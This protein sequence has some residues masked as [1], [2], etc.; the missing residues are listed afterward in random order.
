MYK[1]TKFLTYLDNYSNKLDVSSEHYNKLIGNINQY[2][3]NNN[4]IG[5]HAE[6][7]YNYIDT[8]DSDTVVNNMEHD[9]MEHDN[10][11]HDNIPIKTKNVNITTNVTCI[12]DL[13]QIIDENEYD[14]T[15]EYNI[16]LKSLHDI[17][18]ELDVLNNMIGMESIK[19]SVLNQMLYF[20]QNLDGGIDGGG[21]FKHTVLYGKPGTGKTEIAKLIGQIYSK[22]GILKNNVFKKVTRGDLIAGYLGQTAI[23]TTKVV[24]E[25]IGGV[26]FIDEAYSLAPPDG[27]DIFSKECLDTLCELL[28]DHK[29]DLMVII[30]GY[31]DDL[32]NTFFKSNKGL[33]SRF[34]WKFSMQ[35]YTAPELLLIFK[36]KINE[37]D[38]KLSIE[39]DILSKWFICNYKKFVH[40]GR[41]MEHLLTCVKICHGRRIYGKDKDLRKL[42][43]LDDLTCGYDEFVK[44]IKSQDIPTYLQSIYV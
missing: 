6:D 13:I 33:E 34:I 2:Y 26:L 43:T 32:Q 25:C 42:I 38:W 8:T 22:I 35:P 40:Y 39:Q 10:M 4:T 29:N 15:V 27:N 23:K 37:I 1:S 11:E 3:L 21:D 9:N 12:N 30:A 19:T 31:E 5:F 14:P 7:I 44:S 20:I 41:D 36:K 17:K 16:D 18:T 28:S 24:N